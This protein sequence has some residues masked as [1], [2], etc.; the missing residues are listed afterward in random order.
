MHVVSAVIFFLWLAALGRTILNLVLLPKLSAAAKPLA[1]PLVSIVI[2]ARNE[3]LVIG[4]TVRAFLAQDYRNLEVIVVNDRSSDA[5]AS[6]LANIDDARLTVIDGVE[7]PE[8]WLGKPW[9]LEQGGRR[10]RGELI[11]FV[12]ADVVYAPEAIRAAVAEIERNGGS[13]I[14]LFPFFE[15]HTFGEHVGM[16]ILP[17]VMTGMPLWLFNRWQ[18]P[19]FAMGGG[20][21]NLVRRD[22]METLGYFSTLRNSVID[23]IGLARQVRKSGG[24]TYGVRAEHL[25]RLRMYR[26]ARAI[27]EGFTKNAFPSVGRSYFGAA[28]LLLFIAIAHLLPYGLALTGD[29]WA[30][31]TVILISVIRLVLFSAIG[32]SWWNAVFL[33]PLMMIFWLYIILRSVW[34]TGIR[35]E[36][37]WRG[38]VYDAGQTRFGGDR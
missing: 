29:R 35:N 33:H 19:G 23:D 9:A 14:V 4:E 11:L 7:T 26:G 15:M 32:Y 27:V 36:V 34:I 20:S 31:A 16:P 10:A 3:E 17:F 25:V 37:H 5:T 28:V 2:P 30:I 6:I 18:R 8:G 24:R 12:D 1:E 21:G 22:T 38:R 13:L